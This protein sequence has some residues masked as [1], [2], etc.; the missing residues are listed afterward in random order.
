MCNRKTMICHHQ[1]TLWN[2]TDKW[3][4]ATSDGYKLFRR[5]RQGRRGS[6]VAVY[7]RECFDFVQLNARIDKVESL[8]VRRRGKVNKADILVGVCYGL[9]NQDEEA[10]KVFCKLLGEVT[11]LLGLSLVGNFDFA[12]VCQ[13]YRTDQEG[14][15]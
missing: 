14:R 15:S 12:D 13:K 8:R 7:V 5:D 4:A 2:H 10:D 6:A 3:S 1:K 9:P 11:I